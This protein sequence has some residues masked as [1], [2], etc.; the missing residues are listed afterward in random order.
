LC[1]QLG[2]DSA[3]DLTGQR[4]GRLIAIK[5]T[6][7]RSSSFVVWECLCDC[8]ATH[9]VSSNN[10]KTGDVQ[11]CGCYHKDR[12]RELFALDLTNQKFGKL[13]ALK[14]TGKKRGSFLEWECLCECGNICYIASAA[15]TSGKT[16]SCGCL[17][18]NGERVV[19]MLLKENGINYIMQKSFET[20]RFKNTGALA[21]FDFYVNDKYLIEYDGEQH[22]TH[23][24]NGWNNEEQ[25][26]ITT[27]RDQY[28]NQWC[29]ENN[30]PLIR[31]P[32]T[33][34]DTLCIEDLMLETTQFRVV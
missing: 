25:L 8:G 28:K 32:Y 19:G 1:A 9:Y 24:A 33:K 22:F 20:C 11:S 5:P 15:L 7:R 21:K 4:F 31:I 17:Q 30:I 6:E 27:S 29:K 14:L 16:K 26:K 2:R 3:N 18:S 34:L 23:R 13:T 10:L 12:M